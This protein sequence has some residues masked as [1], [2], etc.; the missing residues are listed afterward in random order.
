MLVVHLRPGF[1]AHL[2]CYTWYCELG[3]HM[4]VSGSP[5]YAHCLSPDELFHFSMVQFI[6][7]HKGGHS[8]CLAVVWEEQNGI[9]WVKQ[10][11][12]QNRCSGNKSLKM[13]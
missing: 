9:T 12:T 7:L 8:T 10:R 13:I 4:G 1:W 11:A 6:H 2:F 3:N 5:R